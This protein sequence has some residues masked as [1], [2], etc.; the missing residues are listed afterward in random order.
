[1]NWLPNDIARCPGVLTAPFMQG[2]QPRDV[3]AQCASCL[4]HTAPA[5]GDRIPHMM[6]PPFDGD[7]PQRIA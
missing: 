1:M 6:P 3:V 7:C 2:T 5:S 4:R